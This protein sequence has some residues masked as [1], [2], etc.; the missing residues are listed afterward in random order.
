MKR[1]INRPLHVK[2]L[3]ILFL[4]LS[5]NVCLANDKASKIDTYL[6]QCYNNG[7][8]NGTALIAE[9]GK[10]IYKK[11]FG[12]ANMEWQIPNDIDT[13]FR[14]GS[15]TKQFTAMLIMQL[16]EAGEISVDAKITDYLP[17]YRKD[18]GDRVTI[19][20]LLTHTSGIPS[21]TGLPGFWSDSTRNH[22][23]VD[24]VVENFC[25]GDLEFEPGS[26][27]RYNNSGYYLLGAI[28]EAVTGKPFSEVLRERILAPLGMK[29]T[30]ID[31]QS[32]ILEKRASG[33]VKQLTEYVKDPYF[34]MRNAYAAG[35]MY[36]TVGNL[37]K[38]DQALYTDKL[39]SQE[40]RQLIFK[41]HVPALG[42]ASY[43]YGWVINKMPLAN[44]SDSV[45]VIAH[46]GGINGFN[47]LI[48]RFV[49]DKHLV[50]LLNNTG[51]ARLNDMCQ[52]I[53]NILYDRPAILPKLSIAET[54]LKTLLEKNLQ[55]A[56]NQYHDL[57]TN[58][59]DKYDFRENELNRLGYQL[60]GIDRVADAIK[61]FKLNVE[62][63]PEAFNPYDSLGEAY[64]I[65]GD[66]ELAI[67]NYKKSIELNPDNTNGI[68]MLEKIKEKMKS[69]AN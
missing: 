49:E 67:E 68:Q 43:G 31:D 52:G 65:K 34:F 24:Y 36:S 61:I 41:P 50:V 39:L 6:T 4:S 29:N 23:D 13:K 51:S 48:A 33:Y 25:S 1:I 44:S 66:Y 12:Y 58:G 62:A 5:R 45:K 19:H 14:I 21:Y 64:M 27:Y 63:Y 8:F 42:T 10:V 16:V 59:E 54:M 57:K 69:V 26:K 7:Q 60:L 17:N 37:Y 55:A 2:L 11:G 35:A 9:R 18:A 30:N 40:Y 46:G 22:Y 32:E 38:W 47:T 28:I 56:I 53:V 20:H 3:L 15:I